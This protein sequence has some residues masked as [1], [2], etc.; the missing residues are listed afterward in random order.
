M[1]ANY[2]KETKGR[3]FITDI[4]TVTELVFQE[5]AE[6]KSDVF[7]NFEAERDSR[8]ILSVSCHR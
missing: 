7:H 2:D 6:H 5:V 8:K 4:R 1:K 3:V